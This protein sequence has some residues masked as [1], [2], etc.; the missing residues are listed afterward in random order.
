[1]TSPAELVTV[2]LLQ[3]P[4]ALR[5]RSMQHGEELVREMTLVAQQSAEQGHSL[6]TRLV[7]LAQDVRTNYGALTAAADVAYAEAAARGDEVIEE[8]VYQVPDTMAAFIKHIGELL[9][10]ADAYCRAGQHLLTLATPH[11]VATYRAWSLQ[12]FERQLSGLP[13]TPWPEYERSSTA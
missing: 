3:V 10:E 6:P 1:M 13:P 8:I 4:V 2:R 12:E 7:E 5:G 11:E 9:E